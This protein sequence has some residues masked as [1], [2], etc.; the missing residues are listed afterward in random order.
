MPRRIRHWFPGATYHVYARGNRHS[1][2]F[3]TPKDFAKYLSILLEVKEKYPFIVHSYCLMTNH[4]HL[5]I[6]TSDHHIGDIMKLAHT[7]YAIYFNRM[8]QLDGH[9]FQG[10][11]G[12]KL[13]LDTHY[14]LEVSRYIHRNPLEANLVRSPEEYKW[15]SYSLYLNGEAS[16]LIDPA[17]TLSHFYNIEAYKE[18]VEKNR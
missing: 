14:F 4:L 5:Q 12:S 1:S 15:S 6:E 9:V 13:I 17:K 2:I 10:R 8:H 7:K 11:Y 18:F 16:P 3:L